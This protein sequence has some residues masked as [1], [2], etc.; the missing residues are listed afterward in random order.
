MSGKQN[1]YLFSEKEVM[2]VI[3]RKIVSL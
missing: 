3:K 2:I 1:R